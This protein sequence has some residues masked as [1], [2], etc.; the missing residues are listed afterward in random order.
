MERIESFR[1]LNAEHPGSGYVGAEEY[2][3]AMRGVKLAALQAD[4]ARERY[5][6]VL[7]VLEDPS[8]RRYYPPEASFYLGEAYRERGGSGDDTRA[9]HA[10]LD[11]IKG[12][13]Q[14]APAYRAL[15]IW[16]M[17]KKDYPQAG[18]YLKQYLTLAPDAPDRTYVEKYYQQ[19]SQEVHP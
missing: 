7:L 16:H 9:E 2:R 10:Y 17:K 12:A 18:G 3:A 4:L 13:P 19:V 15:G 6:S 14:F 1:Q 8:T 5:Q 11:A